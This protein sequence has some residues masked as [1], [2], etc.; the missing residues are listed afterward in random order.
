MLY[1]ILLIILLI[2]CI[3]VATAHHYCEIHNDNTKK[4]IKVW[5]EHFLYTRLVMIAFFD[6]TEDLND[7]ITR[8][9]QNQKDI[10]HIFLNKFGKNSESIIT[11]NLIKHIQLALKVL[12]SVD[13]GSPNDQARVIQEFYEN[14]DTIGGYLDNLFQTNKFKHHMKMHIESLLDNSMAF[15]HREHKKDIETLDIYFGYGT[16]MAFDIASE[17]KSTKN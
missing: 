2:F 9:T 1:F 10:G 11:E 8:L 13:S 12:E 16:D 17:I 5:Q 3:Y 6:K 15:Y 4:I 14:A 7:L